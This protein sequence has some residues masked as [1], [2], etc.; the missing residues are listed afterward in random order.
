M[1][2]IKKF[3][4]SISDDV[5]IGF[6]GCGNM[7]GSII[8]GILKA[9]IFEPKD[10]I[11]SAKNEVNL[12]K[13]KNIGVKTTLNNS[14]IINSRR[15]VFLGVKPQGLDEVS[16]SLMRNF[17]DDDEFEKIHASTLVSVLAGTSIRTLKDALPM[18]SSYVRA[19]PNTPLEVQAGCTAITKLIGSKSPETD[20]NF[21]VVKEIF[22]ALGIAE[23][24]EESKF[25]AITALSGSGPA[26]VYIMIEAL[27][28]AGVKQG[29][30]R[31]L[32]TKFAAQTLFGASKTVLETG[33]HP[34]QLKDNVT[35]SGG[36]TIHG[37]HELE[38]CGLRNAL[39]S[40]VEAATK[41]SKEMSNN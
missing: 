24:I 3:K 35:S 41:R 20:L 23:E 36:T 13:W 1:D 34:G 29:L 32:A 6:I 26:Y 7:A 5:K 31:N 30:P 33:T 4:E 9:K 19:M 39:F 8:K 18:F 22:N 37:I 21:A 14:E 12:L 27:S 38:K 10:I 11:V 16:E 15:I 17:H 40:A 2:N 25:H 28:D